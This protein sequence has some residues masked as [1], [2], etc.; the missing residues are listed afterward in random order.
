MFIACLLTLWK[1]LLRC[2]FHLLYNQF[3]WLY[4]SIS[5]SVSLGEW[6]KWQYAALDFVQ[7][8]RV[9]EIAHGTGHLLQ[10]LLERGYQVTAID[11]SPTMSQIAFGRIKPLTKNPPLVRASAFELPFISDQFDTIITTFPTDFIIQPA[12]LE[13][14]NRLLAEQGRLVIVPSGS[15]QRN[16]IVERVIRGLFWLTGQ[17]MEAAESAE[18]YFAAWQE[19]FAQ[20]KLAL[21]IRPIRLAKSDVIV[22]LATAEK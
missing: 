14:I 1:R 18:T 6:R 15:L 21:Q 10:P 2:G 5:W 8:D 11:L 7:G 4:D 20:H 22:L 12:T 9:L 3:A 16:G 17:Q 13:G 19:R